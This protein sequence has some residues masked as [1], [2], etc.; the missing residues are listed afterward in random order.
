MEPNQE[1]EGLYQSMEKSKIIIYVSSRNN[2]D[3][4]EGAVLKNI[5]LD[6]YEFVNV[7]DE[8]ELEEQAKGKEQAER[9]GFTYLQNNGRGVQYATQTVVD[10]VR[11]NRPECKW[12]VCFQHDIW[13]MQKD[14][15]DRMN[16]HVS[17]PKFNN[18]GLI[19][20]NV[21]DRG[22]YT[23]KALSRYE[24]GDSNVKGMIGMAHL[25]I[26][27]NSARWICPIRQPKLINHEG[28]DTLFQV[29]FPMWA[30]IGI[31]VN[32]WTNHIQPTED[33]QFHLWLPDIAMQFNYKNLPSVILPD[34]YCLN[35]QQEKAKFGI[36][37]NSAQGAMK[38]NS[39][40]FGEYG[41][42]L[43]NWYKR[44]GWDYENTTTFDQVKSHYENTLIRKYFDH[45]I[46]EGPLKPW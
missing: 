8:S 9:L 1:F 20:F 40:H 29:E 26:R 27:S 17:D 35:D 11:E 37:P 4:V 44:W 6:G 12:L 31:N 3:M 7:D 19:G 32:Q 2:Y 25:S 14:F 34:L 33:Y 21:L 22:G 24:S 15:F 36:N 41:Q 46:N 43:I 5:P 18:V 28:F 13:P 16:A 45:N 42:H 38:G 10:W 39:R 23:G 30:A